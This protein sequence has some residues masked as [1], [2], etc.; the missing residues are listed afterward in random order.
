MSS[1]K[2]SPKR[3][4]GFF[5][6]LVVCFLIWNLPL[7]GLPVDGQRCMALSLAAVIWWAVGVIN[8]GYTALALLLGYSLLLNPSVAPRSLIFSLWATPT[9][10]LVISGFLMAAAVQRSGLGRRI[11]LNFILRFAKSYR[12][13]IISC[14]LLGLLLSFMIPHPW[15]RSFMLSSVMIF[16]IKAAGLDGKAAKNIILA[17]FVG[18]V[19]TSMVLLT[20]DSIL[21]SAVSGFVSGATGSSITYLQW[22]VYMGLSGLLASALT[23]TVQILSF[24]GPEKLTIDFGEIRGELHNLGK[25]SGLEK[26]TIAA[27]ALAVVLWCTDMLH[28]IN[29]GW[30][31]VVA[32]LILALPMIEVLNA[33]SWSQVNIGTLLFLCA[34]LAIGSVGAATGMN[35]WILNLLLPG[36]APTNPYV[37]ALV[38]MVIC[39]VVHMLLGSSL[40]VLGIVTPAITAFG[41]MAG[42]PP[43]ASAFIVYTSVALHWLLPIHHINLLVGLGEHYNERN[44]LRLGIPQTLVTVVVVLFQVFMWSVTGLIG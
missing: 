24:K 40:A 1:V 3:I 21:N 4:I 15:P 36:S 5:G 32:T 39:M 10:Y 28:G 27:I 23:C 37:F 31:M 8:P 25:L 43:I 34:A 12:S 38:C 17:V 41:A 14:Y 26:R 44:I 18:S 11:A 13:I 2:F 9:M 30:V 33:D 6:G 22:I 16:V 35:E 29:P 42:F 7:Q 20:G 19:P